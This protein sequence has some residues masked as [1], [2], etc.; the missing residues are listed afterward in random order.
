[1]ASVRCEELAFDSV[2]GDYL[3]GALPVTAIG[4]IGSANTTTTPT[5]TSAVA[6]GP[7]ARTTTVK[8][9]SIGGQIYATKGTGTPVAAAANG[10]WIDTAGFAVM[11]LERGESIAVITVTL[12]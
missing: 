1:M 3:P 11:R 2:R 12:S 9:T 6:F 8:V 5:G 10:T 7:A 4:T